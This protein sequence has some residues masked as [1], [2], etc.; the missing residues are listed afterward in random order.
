MLAI[1]NIKVYYNEVILALNGISL[2]VPEGKIVALLGNN[3]AGKT[4]AL[5]TITGLLKAVNG[6]VEMGSVIFDGKEIH[7]QRPESI[8]RSGISIVPE[9]RGIFKE[10]TV[11]ENLKIGGFTKKY[12]SEDMEFI[13]DYFPVLRERRKSLAG[14]LSGGEQQMLAIGRA[15]MA[16]PR[17]LILD[18]P[19]LGLAPLLVERIFEIIQ[20]INLENNTTIFLVE[21][22]ANVA[23]NI[24]DYGYI[25]ENGQIVFEDTGINL[26]ENDNIKEFYLGLGKD[27]KRKSFQNIKS[28]KRKKRWLS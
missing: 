9:G 8:V 6:K 12:S 27:A 15:L 19:S 7:H 11:E 28:Y 23:L 2:S 13:Y 17:L 25:L 14:Y 5:R 22:N 18:E 24:A 3:G 4:T 20:R 21:Q 10:I 1:N 16:K 26:L